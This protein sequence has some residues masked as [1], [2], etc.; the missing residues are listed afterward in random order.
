M[1]ASVLTAALSC[2]WLV[3][4]QTP[5]PPEAAF[6]SG[7]WIDLSYSYGPNTLYWPTSALFRMDTVAEGMTE[8][9]YYYSA[10]QFCTA[11]HG[12]THLDA[13]VHF[14]QGKPA[15]DEIPIDQ[16][17]G[18]LVVVEVSEACAK[19]RDYQVRVADFEAWEAQH[20][21]IPAGS[22]VLLR[23]GYGKFWPDARQYM[24]TDERGPEAVAK[25]HFPGLHPEAAEWICQ[26]RRI[27]G[28]GLD[29]PSIDYG[30]STSFE[31]HQILAREHIPIMEN[32]ANVSE[33]PP[34]GAFLVALPMKIAG[35]SGAPLR[36]AALLPESGH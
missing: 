30:Q 19:E 3:A 21:G 2:L 35:G 24:G 14:A 20:G 32:V 15:V 17:I 4:C 9:G 27:K 33:L 5:P 18:P 34:T 7:K 25:L 13:P 23:T 1:K 11:E 28:I 26:N 8:K 29:T 16:L 31:T 36:I 6:P 10:Y 22:I 12:G